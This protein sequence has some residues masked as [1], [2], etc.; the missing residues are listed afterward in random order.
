MYKVLHLVC[1]I[2]DVI[3]WYVLAKT[4][5]RMLLFFKKKTKFKIKQIISKISQFSISSHLFFINLYFL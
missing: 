5:Q 1:I 3:L 4:P 2:Q